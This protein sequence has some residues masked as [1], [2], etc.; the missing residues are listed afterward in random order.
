MFDELGAGPSQHGT[1]ASRRTEKGLE[2]RIGY[3]IYHP[4]SRCCFPILIFTVSI[5]LDLYV[6]VG[7]GGRAR[8]ARAY[9][10]KVRVRG[11]L[12][13]PGVRLQVSIIAAWIFLVG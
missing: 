5:V 10:G 12:D 1:W 2:D 4:V 11:V 13:L 8:E 6:K 7:G 9:P 3:T